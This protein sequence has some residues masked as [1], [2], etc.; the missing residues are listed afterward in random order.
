[1]V[2]ILQ[3]LFANGVP[4]FGHGIVPSRNTVANLTN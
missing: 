4:F 3:R 2:K 1:M